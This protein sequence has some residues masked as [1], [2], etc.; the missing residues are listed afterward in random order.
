[1]KITAQIT[2]LREA[3]QGVEAQEAARITRGL[4]EATDR[5]KQGLRQQVAKAGLSDRLGRT[6]RG[7]V[8]PAGRDSL[9]PAGW[10]T[11]NAPKIISAFAKG[12]T[13]VPTNG[14]RALAIPTEAVPRTRRGV[15][16][17]PFEVENHFNQDLEV[18]RTKSGRPFL[19]LEL[20][21]AQS[22]RGRRGFRQ[23]TQT[24]VKGRK[25]LAAREKQQVI[26][27]WLD[28]RVKMPKLLD[29]DDAAKRW[30]ID[31]SQSI[32]AGS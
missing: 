32:G 17:T 28:T 24:R 31:F 20:V 3:L 30:S 4:R 5:A 1:M 19:Y 29:L 22:P 21:A 26:M 16:M 27:F 15:P 7:N 23:A 14:R 12:A 2:G 25:G 6:W 10:L 18:G 11:S 8:Y 9:E 13:I